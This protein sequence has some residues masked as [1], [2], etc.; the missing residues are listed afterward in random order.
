[1]MQA[2][3]IHVAAK[4]SMDLR[5]AVRL[6]EASYEH[7]EDGHSLSGAI[8]RWWGHVLPHTDDLG[9]DE[10]V[11]GY[12]LDAH[13]HTLVHGDQALPLDVGTIYVLDPHVRHGVL[14]SDNTGVLCCYISS[15]KI[16]DRCRIDWDAFAEEALGAARSLVASPP[17]DNSEYT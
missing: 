1:M 12:V 8:W 17:P 9:M 11:L 4:P 15:R 2:E 13:G 14:G 3:I 16:K 6:R 7:D 5:E 10:L